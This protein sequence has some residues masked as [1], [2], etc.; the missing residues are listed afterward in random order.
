M[1]L[2]EKVTQLKNDFDDVYD[3]GKQTAYDEFWDSY[4]NNGAAQSCVYMFA[5]PGWNKNT[6]KPKYDIKPA[7][8]SPGIFYSATNL[9]DLAQLMTDAGISWDLS[10][11]SLQLGSMFQNCTSLTHIPSMDLSTCINCDSMF[12]GC[13]KLVTIGGIVFSADTPRYTSTFKSCKAL[14]S[15]IA[16]GTIAK[17]IDLGDCEVLNKASITSFINTLSAT[18]TGQTVTLS[19]SAVNAA[20]GIDVDDQSTYP[21]GSEYNTLIGTKSNWTIAYK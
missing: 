4:Q 13:K 19:K 14:V 7:G 11:Q 8:W 15:C 9:V 16:S 3:A 10:A 21:T 17:T 6:F 5:G 2:S 18:A 12:Y 20:F 1:N